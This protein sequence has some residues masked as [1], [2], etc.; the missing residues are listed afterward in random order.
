VWGGVYESYSS[1]SDSATSARD[2]DEVEARSAGIGTTL[3][4]YHSALVLG[5]CFSLGAC[6]G[7]VSC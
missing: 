5:L 3:G 4:S 1:G 2:E 6:V 7:V